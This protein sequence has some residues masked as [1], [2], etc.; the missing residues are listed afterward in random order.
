MAQETDDD[1]DRGDSGEFIQEITLDDVLGVFAAVDAPAILT[2]DV[3]DELDISRESARQKLTRLTDQGRIERRK[4]GRT[5]T[6]WH[7]PASLRYLSRERDQAIA[8]GDTV[9][10]D[11]DTHSLVD[12]GKEVSDDE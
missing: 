8:V 1:R 5:I 4:K 12:A 9:Y 2:S 3:I 11:G 7:A 10:E 6:W